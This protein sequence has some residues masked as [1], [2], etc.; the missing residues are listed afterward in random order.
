M[1]RWETRRCSGE[2][3]ENGEEQY[4]EGEKHG[5]QRERWEKVKKY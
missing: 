1:V 5:R 2:K 3:G 4:N